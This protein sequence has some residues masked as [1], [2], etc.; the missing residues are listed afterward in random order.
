MCNHVILV[1]LLIFSISSQ[2][3]EK[4]SWLR[5]HRLLSKY[6]NPIFQ[7]GHKNLFL[8]VD[9]SADRNDEHKSNN[10]KYGSS[11]LDQQ[12]NLNFRGSTGFKGRWIKSKPHL[13]SDQSILVNIDGFIQKNTEIKTNYL[14]GA[15]DSSKT[16]SQNA[17]GTMTYDGKIRRYPLSG[18]LNRYLFIEAGVKLNA[19]GHYFRNRSRSHSLGRGEILESGMTI[20]SRYSIEGFLFPAIGCG[21]RLPVKPVYTAFEIERNLRKLKAVKSKLSDSTMM[22]LAALCGSIDSFHL[23]RERPDKFIMSALDSILRD[24]PS[25]DTANYDAFSLFKV[26]E[27]LTERFFILFHGSEIKIRPHFY[28]NGSYYSHHTDQD[29]PPEE[30]SAEFECFFNSPIHLAWTFPVA[31]RL[32]ME[33]TVSPPLD[34]FDN[35][36]LRHYSSLKL[37]YF[38]T[39]RIMLDFSVNDLSTIVIVPDGKPGNIL[40][41]AT[42]FMEDK[43][44]LQLSAT[45]KFRSSQRPLSQSIMK[46]QHEKVSLQVGYDF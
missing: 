5:F 10:N 32:F 39:N 44:T 29:S 6:D 14:T 17:S 16:L 21:K 24:D 42:F 36:I 41:N 38:I 46:D 40:F 1:L 28:S 37:Y 20:G 11:Y 12:Y 27:T 9:Y 8:H 34:F 31:S 25:L 4:S 13:Q 43:L 7:A 18:R 45:K 2:A 3:V 22:A 26:Y 23:T 19:F 35:N 15:Y 30:M 33:Y